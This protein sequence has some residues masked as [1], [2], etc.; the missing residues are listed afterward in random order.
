[1]NKWRNRN[2]ER[3]GGREDKKKRQTE[4][5]REG[6]RKTEKERKRRWRE[7]VVDM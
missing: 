2:R 3:V 5:E 1:M 7:R 6:Y 4:R